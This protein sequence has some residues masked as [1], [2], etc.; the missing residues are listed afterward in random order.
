MSAVLLLRHDA[1]RELWL[2]RRR[3]GIGASEIAAVMGIS[4]YDSPFSLWWRK[5]MGWDMEP[6]PEMRVGTFLE[7]AI[8]DWFA[9]QGDPN[10]NLTIARGGLYGSYDRSWQL[11]TPDRLI[12]AAC[13]NCDGDGF[14]THPLIHSSICEQCHGDGIGSPPLAVLECKWVAYSWDGWGE[15]DSNEIPVH[16]RAQVLWQMDVM[17]LAEA[18]V[19]ALGPGGFRVFR[20]YRDEKDLTMMREAGRRFMESLAEGQPPDVDDH[21]AT[22]ATIRRINTEIEDREQEIPAPV[23]AG[24]LRS[25]RFKDLAERVERRYSATMRAYLG[26]AKTAVCAGRTIAARTSSDQLR[27][28]A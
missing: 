22:L 9:L 12:H 17:D 4:P 14:A 11:A 23:A 5:F 18:F 26:T 20:I 2:K 16:Y 6:S 21:T 8:A 13:S 10:S 1:D 19:C 28:K 15:D 27:R 7:S 3:D 24:W 25:K